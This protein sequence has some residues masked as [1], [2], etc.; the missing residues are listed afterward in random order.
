MGIRKKGR[1]WIGIRGEKEGY[2]WI[3]GQKK[4]MYVD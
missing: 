2:R 3:L 1:E 4:G